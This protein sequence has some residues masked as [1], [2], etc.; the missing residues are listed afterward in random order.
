MEI[1]RDK[2]KIG[3]K[4][5]ISLK[6][7]YDKIV[8]GKVREIL[9]KA[10]SHPHGIM[11]KLEDENI[12]R[13]KTFGEEFEDVTE[14][15]KKEEINIKE[16]IKKGEKFNIEFKSSALWSLHWTSQ[17]IKESKSSELHMFG[18]K[19]SKVIIAETI[20]ALMNSR[21]G[22]LVIGIKENKNDMVD[23]IIGVKDEFNKLKDPC[24]DGYSRMIIDE[25]I[26]PYFP[27][28]IYNH[29]DEYLEI[30]FPV[31][32]DKVLCLVKVTKGDAKV[33]LD[34]NKHRIFFIRTGAETRFIEGEELV[35]YCEKRFS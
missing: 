10:Q 15:T 35:E 27:A 4:V 6:G 34:L 28:K 21:G 18:Q 33:F 9:T 25:I 32:D 12:G 19:A 24:E 20:A 1:T 31:E 7:N 8:N 13:V 23:K 16:L 5:G 22:H 3:S 26:R 30:S 29:L 17:Q 11:V 14:E 2:I